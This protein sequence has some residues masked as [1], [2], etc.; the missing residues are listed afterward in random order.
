M[1]RQIQNTLRLILC[2]LFLLVALLGVSNSLFVESL[3]LYE[4]ELMEVEGESTDSS[5]DV[6]DSLEE[7]DKILI[8]NHSVISLLEMISKQYVN[9]TDGLYSLYMSIKSPPPEC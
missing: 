7:L 4:I 2:K 8:N 3:D 5:L 6:E 9:S 1:S